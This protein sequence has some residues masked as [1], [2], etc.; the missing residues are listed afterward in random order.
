MPTITRWYIKTSFGYFILAMAIGIVLGIQS[1]QPT[2]FPAADLYPTYIHIL[3][4]GWL[5]MLIIG[6]ALWMFPKLTL[7]L[8]RG[9]PT[10]GWSSYI[11]LNAVC[12]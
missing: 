10:L 1:M 8:P 9:N 7:E 12:C 6:V 5:T 4:E 2:A 3:T 11:L